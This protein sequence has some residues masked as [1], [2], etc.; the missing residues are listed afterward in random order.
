MKSLGFC[1]LWF[2]WIGVCDLAAQP[3]QLDFQIN[4]RAFSLPLTTPISVDGQIR[5]LA[6]L[7]HL[8][9]GLHVV[10]DE[11]PAR[12]VPLLIFSYSLIGPVT[13]VN[14]LTVLGQPLTLTS[15]TVRGGFTDEA[16]LPIGTH[17]VIAAMVDANGSMLA[18]LVERRTGPG[19]RFLLTGFVQELGLT[20]GLIRVGEQWVDATGLV[21]QS[22]PGG[23]P[24][25]GDHVDL[26]AVAVASFP[27]GSVL[28]SV[29]DGRRV[30]PVPVG[31][32]GAAGFLQGLVSTLPAADQFTLGGLTVTH[33]AT[34]QFQFG[35]VDDLDAGVAVV[36]DG[37][38]TGANS[39]TADVVE[40]FRPVVRFTAPVAP[41]AVVAGQQIS[42]MGVPVHWSAQVRDQDGILGNGLAQPRQVEVRGYLDRAGVA[43]ATRVRDRGIADANAVRLRGPVQAIGSSTFQIQGLVVDT[44]GA[45]F[46]DDL[47]N[48][49]TSTQFFA[50]VLI[51]D[52]V[53]VSGSVFDAANGTLTGGDIVLIGAEPFV[54]NRL[55]TAAV[56]TIRA[57]TASAYALPDPVFKNGFE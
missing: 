6:D 25:V 1:L 51:D 22:C 12:G 56:V 53:D 55:S 46:F 35:T 40:F 7:P 26:S 20:P 8:R 9:D 52:L 19:N 33:T 13:A 31:T 49:I 29:T 2:G 24:V 21:W 36:V 28:Q 34:T 4:E 37:A 11:T 27:P 30:M 50:S 42:L 47:L 3:T 38:Y 17:L 57:G 45:L 48:P 5:T 41:A 32:L 44:T 10:W 39:L 16:L 43:W 18:T 15:D 14:P 54:V 23:Q